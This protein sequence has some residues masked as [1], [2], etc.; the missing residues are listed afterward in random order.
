MIYHQ[1]N[2][3]ALVLK[4]CWVTQEI[5][6]GNL[7][8]PFHDVKIVPFSTSSLNLKTLEKKEETDKNWKIFKT[9]RAF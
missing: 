3:D 7:S 9:K 8:K 4:G 6:I 5:T 1:A 2:F